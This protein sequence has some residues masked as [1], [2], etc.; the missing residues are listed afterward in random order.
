MYQLATWIRESDQEVFER[1]TQKHPEMEVRNA[2]VAEAE[3]AKAH[4]LLVTG[5]PDISA[6]F[7][8]EPVSDPSL[9]RDPEPERVAPQLRCSARPQPKHAA[10]A[11]RSRPAPAGQ[12]ARYPR[13]PRAR[14]R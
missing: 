6:Q 11:R 1:F 8:V 9:I 7:H 10:R 14:V 5:G 12:V 2:R 13:R 4:G 3:V